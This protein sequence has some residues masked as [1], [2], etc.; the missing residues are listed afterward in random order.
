MKVPDTVEDEGGM[1]L[2]C[3]VGSLDPLFQVFGKKVVILL[4][5]LTLSS[6]KSSEYL[7]KRMQKCNLKTYGWR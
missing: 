1:G 4:I 7:V 6:Y 2:K 3:S 5:L